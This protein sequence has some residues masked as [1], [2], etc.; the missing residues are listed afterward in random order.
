MILWVTNPDSQIHV[1]SQFHFDTFFSYCH[2]IQANNNPFSINNDLDLKHRTLK[3]EFIQSTLALNSCMKFH[4]AM[5]TIN[6]N[7]VMQFHLDQIKDDTNIYFCAFPKPEV[8]NSTIHTPCIAFISW[9]PDRALHFSNDSGICYPALRSVLL[10]CALWH[11]GLQQYNNVV[12]QYMLL[13]FNDTD[14]GR[15]ERYH[16]CGFQ[17]R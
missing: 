10:A 8:H 7:S 16:R 5:T 9:L 12:F 4:L 2:I 3:S 6:S 13:H 15:Q 1:W 11:S 17:V 14:S